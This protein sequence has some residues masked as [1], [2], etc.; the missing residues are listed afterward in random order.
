[1]K[2]EDSNLLTSSERNP[3]NGNRQSNRRQQTKRTKIQRPQNRRRKSQ[4]LIQPSKSRLRLQRHHHAR[5]LPASLPPAGLRL[6]RP[7][8]RFRPIR[9]AFH[10]AHKE[11]VK[12]QKQR[13]NS[14]IGFEPQKAA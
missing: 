10:R 11:L 13:L 9:R 1:M 7:V 2:P 6:P 14:E 3:S 8:P 4:I 5:A 12:T